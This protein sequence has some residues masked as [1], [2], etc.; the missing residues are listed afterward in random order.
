[1][2]NLLRINDLKLSVLNHYISC[3]S[4]NDVLVVKHLLHTAFI[5]LLDW[6][7]PVQHSVRRFSN[8]ASHTAS[9][10]GL[11]VDD[12]RG[13]IGQSEKETPETLSLLFLGGVNQSRYLFTDVSGQSIGHIFKEYLN[14]EDRTDRLFRNVDK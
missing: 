2:Q 12:R 7:E 8:I 13:G 11:T 5:L 1:M 6:K 10:G 3:C 14:L 9:R 4:L